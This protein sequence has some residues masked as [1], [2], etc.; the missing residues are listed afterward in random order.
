MVALLGSGDELLRLV[1]AEVDADVHVR[2]NEI[3]VTGQPADNAF[4]VRVFDELIALLGTGQQLRPDSVRRVI[5]MLR[6]GGSERPADVLSLDIISRRGRTIRP[7][8]L[9]QKR[10]VDAIDAHTIVFGIGPAGTGKT[11]LAM[12]KAVQALQTK[13]VNRIILT[14][15]AVEAGERLGYLPGTLSEKIDPYL[16]P[17][18]DALH[19]MVDPESIPRLMQAGTIEVAPLAY[20]RGRAQPYRSEVLTPEGFVPIG[21]L[22][23]GDLVIGSD[24]TPTPVLGVYPQGVKQ[25]Y[26]VATQ[27]G[28]WTLACG[29]HLWTVATPEDKRRGKTR[30]LET[31]E[32]VGKLRRGAIRRY[33]L[34]LVQPVHFEPTDVPLDP[35]ALGLLLGD[36]C[37]TTTTTPAFS[38]A[39]PELA[40]ALEHALD[41]ISVE[42]RSGYDYVLR[43]RDGGRG[44]LRIANPV[45][46]VLRQLDL[47]GTTS[48]TKFVPENYLRNSVTV[49]TAVLQ[50]LLDSDG[51]PVTQTGRTC[52]IQYTT[53]SPGLKDDVTFLVRSLGGVVYTR[54]RESAG[55]PPGRANGRPVEYREDAYILDIRLPA[56]IQPFRLT[57]KR[58]AYELAGG[59]RPMRF[60]DSIEPIGEMDTLCIQVGAQDSLYVT[61]DFLV[62][63][64]TLND[65][66]VILDEAQNTT[67]EQMKMFLTRLGFGSKIVVTGDVTQVDLP[68]GAQS[69]LKIVREILDG[70][71]DVHFANLTSSDVV[72]HRLV[73]DIVDAYERWDNAKQQQNRPASGPPV[74]ANRPRRQGS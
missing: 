44:G 38:T 65:A 63:H 20:M 60:I 12:A 69:G 42:R 8:T 41:G 35:Y 34:P 19:D 13:Q 36:G 59:G 66:F 55:R 72:R 68:G 1:E 14:R 61:D 31:Q 52:R 30:T 56:D 70:I 17:L 11:Y 28:A 48:A 71:D 2:G 64:N 5:G 39:D 24:G 29:E 3:A 7:K 47:A 67:A 50:G 27:D 16:R 21:T 57:R 74:R 62:T 25:V 18:Y 6:S 4:A 10:Y 9:N 23:V 15:P 73:G 51:G 49:R 43:H 33:E 45:T 40:V 58:R 32:M 53:T 26:R 22:R 54:L 46:V 37:L